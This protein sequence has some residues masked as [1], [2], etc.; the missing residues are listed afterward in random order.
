[1]N[2]IPTAEAMMDSKNGH[3]YTHYEEIADLMRDF[4][5]L[6]VDAALT[7]AAD[8]AKMV[9]HDGHHKTDKRLSY[10]Q[11]GADNL[12]ISKSSILEAYPQSKIE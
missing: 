11:S 2:K 7:A 8:Q 6:H 4:A 12:Q 5:K 10:F 9:Y 1:M 3:D